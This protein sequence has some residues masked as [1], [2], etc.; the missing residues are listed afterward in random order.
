[1][2]LITRVA[3]GLVSSRAGLIVW[4]HPRIVLCWH[5]TLPASTA[6]ASLWGLGFGGPRVPPGDEARAVLCGVAGPEPLNLKTW[7][8][9]LR[10]HLR[11]T[12]RRV[13]HRP[14]QGAYLNMSKAGAGL[15]AQ[16]LRQQ[17][18]HLQA[19]CRLVPVPGIRPENAD[20]LPAGCL[21]LTST[22]APKSCVDATHWAALG[23]I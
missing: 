6:A 9:E 22:D 17:C 10:P 15:L 20:T 14:L 3:V 16:R 19:S 21:L 5:C 2:Y 4:E 18:H 1:M 13:W 11:S 23:H 7:P 12:E 8:G